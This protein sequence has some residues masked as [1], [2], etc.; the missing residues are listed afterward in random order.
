MDHTFVDEKSLKSLEDLAVMLTSAMVSLMTLH[1]IQVKAIEIGIMPEDLAERANIIA[2]DIRR[3]MNLHRAQ[4]EAVL[5]L[6]P[7]DF[8]HE[9]IIEKLKA[10]EMKKVRSM[11][12]KARAKRDGNN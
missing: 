7:D 9:V 6:L 4:T 1:N 10:G 8:N 12:R 2:Y 3:L 5:D 11:A